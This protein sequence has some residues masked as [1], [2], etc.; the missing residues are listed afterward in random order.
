MQES[1]RAE[2]VTV[3]GR[4]NANASSASARQR[5]ASDDRAHTIWRKLLAQFKPY[6][7][8]LKSQT[9]IVAFMRV[10]R[11]KFETMLQQ[12]PAPTTRRWGC[13]DIFGDAS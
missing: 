8:A 9:V 2:C 12:Q 6:Y 11:T 4:V 5:L 13:I 7:A 10:Q 1:R 3:A